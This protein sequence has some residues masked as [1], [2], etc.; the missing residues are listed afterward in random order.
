MLRIIGRLNYF[1]MGRGLVDGGPTDHVRTTHG[2]T[3]CF[4]YVLIPSVSDMNFLFIYN[5]YLPIK[6]TQFCLILPG[7]FFCMLLNLSRVCSMVLAPSFNAVGPGSI[8]GEPEPCMW[9]VF[10]Q[11]LPDCVG[12]LYRGFTSDIQILHFFIIFLIFLS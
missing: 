2:W 5:K 8:P 1:K 9:V 11:S 3:T 10:V 12:F 6:N 4:H 7:E